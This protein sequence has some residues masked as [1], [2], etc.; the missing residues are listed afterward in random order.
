MKKKGVTLRMRTLGFVSLFFFGFLSSLAGELVV[1]VSTEPPSLDPTTNPAAAI[2][3]IFHH[4]L[5]EGLVKVNAEGDYVPCLAI[6]WEV[7]G[8]GLV[9]TF[10]LREGVLFHDGTPFD[11]EAVKASFLRHMD[12]ETPHPHP[13]YYEEITEIRVLDERTMQF[14][15]ERPV[16]YFLAILAQADSVIVPTKSRIGRPLSEHPVGTGPFRFVEWRPGI[17]I[18]LERN[19]DYYLPWIPMLDRV[20]FRFIPDDAVRVMALR[21]GDVDVAVD[22]S[23]QLARELERD[24]R[25]RVI[26]GPMNLVQILAI[27]NARRPFDDIRVRR[28]IAHGIDREKI[29][30]LVSLG[31]GTPIGSHITPGMPYYVDLTGL[32][33][34]D[35]VKARELLSEAGFPNG[36]DTTL[37]L[38]SN[39]EFHVRTGEVIAAQLSVVGIRARIELVDWGTWLERV[40]AQ[41]DYD[42]TVI[43]HVGRLDPA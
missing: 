31:Y 27:N 39:Y 8:D 28:A 13:E 7:S 30:E 9:W 15:L 24:P 17:E 25:F 10:R 23:P 33:P 1:A 40:Y 29:I 43:G 5:Y 21:A 12:P 32:Y 42:L 2:D 34:H 3:L 22:V 14:V 38:P 19:P 26:S 4:N 18:V 11:A 37:T 35:P 20:V 6:S 16:P 41:A 36:F